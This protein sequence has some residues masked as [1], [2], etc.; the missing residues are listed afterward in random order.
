V[1]F[2]KP[3]FQAGMSKYSIKDGSIEGG[4]II[5]W[6]TFFHKFEKIDLWK[7]SKMWFK[8][9]YIWGLTWRLNLSQFI[10]NSI[11]CVLP[12]CNA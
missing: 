2:S 12:E 6:E 11:H 8:I 7:Y 9:F 4:K 3:I 10:W 5:D 1:K